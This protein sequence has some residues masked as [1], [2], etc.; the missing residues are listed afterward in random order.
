MAAQVWAINKRHELEKGQVSAAAPASTNWRRSANS[1]LTVAY[2]R[3]GSPVSV[4]LAIQK[5]YVP[6][7]EFILWSTH[8]PKGLPR[9]LNT[10]LWLQI[11]CTH[12]DLKSVNRKNVEATLDGCSN[13]HSIWNRLRLTQD[14]FGWVPSCYSG[15][16]GPLAAADAV[17]RGSL[18]VRRAACLWLCALESWLVP[19]FIRN[20][21]YA[22]ATGINSSRLLLWLVVCHTFSY[23]S[24]RVYSLRMRR[25]TTVRRLFRRAPPSV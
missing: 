8:K 23:S 1:Q 18:A 9:S 6:F 19:A 4:P 5:N 20:P 14:T 13:R 2:L 11:I 17:P 12:W 25:S 24:R 15:V 16:D 10:I 7:I 22:T 21:K 3:G